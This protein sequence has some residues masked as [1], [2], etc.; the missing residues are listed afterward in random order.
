MFFFINKPKTTQVF[1]SFRES[2]FAHEAFDFRDR[3][4]EMRF[5]I[6][7]NKILEEHVKLRQIQASRLHCNFK[8]ISYPFKLENPPV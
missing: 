2:T 6:H 5:D 4:F 8:S 7:R 3:V 1:M